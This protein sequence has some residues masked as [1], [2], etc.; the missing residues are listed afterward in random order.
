VVADR[1]ASGCARDAECEDSCFHG[2][3][4]GTGAAG[5]AYNACAAGLRERVAD[6]E[7]HTL[8]VREARRNLRAEVAG[9]RERRQ[10]RRDLT[11]GALE[12]R[13]VVAARSAVGQM[14]PRPRLLL[15]AC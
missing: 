15:R 7:Q 1:I 8:E 10:D 6:R 2:R 3:K 12:T 14:R 13:D 9:D 4:T 5:D 11:P